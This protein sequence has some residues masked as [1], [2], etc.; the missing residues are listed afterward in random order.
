M[1]LLSYCVDADNIMTFLFGSKFVQIRKNN[2]T[3]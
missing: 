3:E 1:E 2:M